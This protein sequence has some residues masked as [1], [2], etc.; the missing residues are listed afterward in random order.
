MTLNATPESIATQMRW[1]EEYLRRLK[2][3]NNGSVDFEGSLFW[4]GEIGV[5]DYAY[6]LGST[7]AGD[8]IRPLAISAHSAFLTVTN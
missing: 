7:V 6:T 5:N 2:K 3:N 4:V 1:F 8:T